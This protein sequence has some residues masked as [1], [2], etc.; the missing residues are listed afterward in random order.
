MKYSDSYLINNSF[1]NKY[2]E[3]ISIGN[4][5]DLHAIKE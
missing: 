3:I 5:M 4:R 2:V 1:V